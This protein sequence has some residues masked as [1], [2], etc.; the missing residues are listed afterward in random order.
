[1][2]SPDSSPIMRQQTL[3]KSQNLSLKI[4]SKKLSFTHFFLASVLCY[5]TPRVTS[6]SSFCRRP[7]AT[8]LSCCFVIL[9]FLCPFLTA[10]THHPIVASFDR[11]VIGD[12]ELLSFRASRNCFLIVD[13]TMRYEPG[14]IE[15]LKL[16][17]RILFAGSFVNN[18]DA[19]TDVM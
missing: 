16:C 19:E 1:M 10:K 12:A 9:M 14:C 4:S 3:R 13:D 7:I 6:S 11:T 18:N 17:C 8:D 5:R 2:H 15:S